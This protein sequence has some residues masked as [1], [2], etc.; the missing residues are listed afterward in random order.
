MGRIKL[1]FR[2][3]SPNCGTTHQKSGTK[4]SNQKLSVR[5]LSP[6]DPLRY[7]S[8]HHMLDSSKAAP[9]LDLKLKAFLLLKQA[10]HLENSVY[11]LKTLGTHKA[12]LGENQIKRSLILVIL[13]RLKTSAV[14]YQ[15][16]LKRFTTLITNLTSNRFIPSS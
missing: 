7:Q 3:R 10:V 8:A 11:S 15:N 6:M 2:R 13:K 4:L 14:L 16:E 12:L 9:E 5:G 1:I